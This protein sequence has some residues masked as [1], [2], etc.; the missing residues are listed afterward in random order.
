MKSPR[1]Q[2]ASTIKKIHAYNEQ[3]K[4]T[5]ASNDAIDT[6]NLMSTVYHKDLIHALEQGNKAKLRHRKI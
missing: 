4:K 6:L 2:I 1:D 3:A 5:G